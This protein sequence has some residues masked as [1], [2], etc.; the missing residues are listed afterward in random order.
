MKITKRCCQKKISQ[1][2]NFNK[3]GSDTCR[4]GTD[5]EGQHDHCLIGSPTTPKRIRFKMGPIPTRFYDL[6]DLFL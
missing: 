5:K 4:S 6:L 1:K 2:D 3:L